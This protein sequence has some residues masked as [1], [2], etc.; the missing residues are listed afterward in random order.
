MRVQQRSQNTGVSS[1]FQKPDS[2]DDFVLPLDLSDSLLTCTSS[3]SAIGGS[4]SHFGTS[5]Q[6]T[7]HCA[8]TFSERGR[9]SSEDP[10]E[11]RLTPSVDLLSYDHLQVDFSALGFKS[12]GSG[13]QQA[14]LV[15]QVTESLHL[16]SLG[17]WPLLKLLEE[18]QKAWVDSGQGWEE[19]NTDVGDGGGGRA[20][21]FLAT[22]E[23][24]LNVFWGLRGGGQVTWASA[25]SSGHDHRVLRWAPH[26]AQRGVCFSLSLCPSSCSLSFSLK[27][28][29]KI[30]VK[31]VFCTGLFLGCE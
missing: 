5:L 19:N 13:V 23:Y 2:C 25:F 16:C 10:G 31:N 9:K 8:G 22:S 7:C 12:P 18:G 24:F 17:W 1:G 20:A 3:P 27:W 30:F 15:A 14:H 21:R 26:R 28:I 4:P 11:R 6:S 29:N